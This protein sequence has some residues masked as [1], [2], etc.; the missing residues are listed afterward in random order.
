M[1]KGALVTYAFLFAF[2]LLILGVALLVGETGLSPVK[3]ARL[4]A[5]PKSPPPSDV[6]LSL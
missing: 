6:D 2:A 5:P 3:P 4:L 1:W